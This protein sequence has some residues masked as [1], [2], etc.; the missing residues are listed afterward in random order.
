MY[1]QPI[2]THTHVR[3]HYCTLLHIIVTVLC[4]HTEGTSSEWQNGTTALRKKRQNS[5]PWWRLAVLGIFKKYDT[6]GSA[7]VLN[8]ICMYWYSAGEMLK[9]SAVQSQERYCFNKTVLQTVLSPA[10]GPDWLLVVRKQTVRPSQ[11]QIQRCSKNAAIHLLFRT[12]WA[13]AAGHSNRHR[14]PWWLSLRQAQLFWV[15]TLQ[16]VSRQIGYHCEHR[17]PEQHN[18]TQWVLL[19]QLCKTARGTTMSGFDTAPDLVWISD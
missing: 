1:T 17:K 14:L 8:I 2:H 19:C 13:P 16:L 15:V 5:S 4:S 6:R 3:T 9:I 18:F 10:K 7:T 11:H 12:P